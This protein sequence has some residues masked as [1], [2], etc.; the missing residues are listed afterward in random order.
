MTNNT[1]NYLYLDANFLTAYFVENHQDNY[2]SRIKMF[3][4]LEKNK[5]LLIS[6]LTL[7]ETWCKVKLTLE[8]Q[9]PTEKRKPF[10]EFY[11]D[12]KRI[13]DSILDHPLMKIIQFENDLIQG[14]KNA[15]ENIKNYNLRPRDAFHYAMMKD[16]N[17]SY[18][19]TKDKDFNKID[20]VDVISY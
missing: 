11:G 15:L 4:L 2:S 13:L 3:E 10:S 6:C 17:V 12:L 18:I 16:L 20:D 8:K 9:V 14:V 19:V 7:D 1:D 5:N